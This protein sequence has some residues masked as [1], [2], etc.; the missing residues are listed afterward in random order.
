VR[1]RTADDE[2]DHLTDPASLALLVRD[3]QAQRPVPLGHVVS[4]LLIQEQHEAIAK[5]R[6]E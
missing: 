5:R 2:T 6:I 4:I 3:D 1:L